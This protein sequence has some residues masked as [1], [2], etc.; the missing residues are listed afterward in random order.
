MAL[1]TMD[2]K[3]P[4][5]M[6]DTPEILVSPD[7]P[8]SWVVEELPVPEEYPAAM[9]VT[10]AREP[11]DLPD[12][13]DLPVLLATVPSRA[14]PETLV[15]RVS[16]DTPDRWESPA[17]LELLDTREELEREELPVPMPLTALALSVPMDK[18][19]ENVCGRTNKEHLCN[20]LYSFDKHH[21]YCNYFLH[22]I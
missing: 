14:H 8:E 20:R 7:S 10:E 5:D 3:D 17:P 4:E 19:E 13:V 12:P 11:L 16:R 18:R 15:V 2:L 22:T 6:M 1:E 21:T 9:E